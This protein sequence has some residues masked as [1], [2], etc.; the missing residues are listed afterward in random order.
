[1][2]LKPLLHH[3]AKSGIFHRQEKWRSSEA[4]RK[5]LAIKIGQTRGGKQAYS[6]RTQR[7]IED[8]DANRRVSGSIRHHQ[9]QF[10]SGETQK[11]L[12]GCIF[13]ALNLDPSSNRKN[14]FQNAICD[15][16]RDQ[17]GQ[18]YDQ[19]HWMIA[20]ASLKSIPKL[21]SQGEY[22]VGVAVDELACLCQHQFSALAREELLAEIF[23]ERS[24][25]AADGGLRETQF[26][27]G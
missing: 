20:G 6:G 16:L 3:L 26:F 1:M 21:F 22:L 4:V 7:V 27:A 13:A 14:R 10:V 8:A 17:V 12:L 15:Q 25:L 18:A 19:P 23:L 2:R 5:A 11:Q 24:Q 9:V